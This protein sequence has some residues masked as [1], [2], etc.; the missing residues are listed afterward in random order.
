MRR[1]TNFVYALSVVGLLS[2]GAQ[3]NARADTFVFD[4]EDQTATAL[5]RNGAL[6]VLTMTSSLFTVTI[7][8]PGAPFDIVENV[9]LQ[10]KPTEFGQR[11]LDPFFNVSNTP[12][13]ADFSQAVTSVSLDMGDYAFDTDTLILEAY[14][15]LGGGGTLLASTTFSLVGVS[16]DFSFATL[17]VFASGIRSIRFIGGSAAFPNSVFYDNLTVSTSAVPE[18]ATLLLLGT[19]LTGLA[20]SI[21]TR[22]KQ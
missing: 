2:V 8:R 15:E 7:T 4:F 13:I 9:G 12:F 6:N 18:P 14:S 10:A 19:A 21:K 11:S 17:S 3:L 1:F 16:Q 20:A 22:R 5:P